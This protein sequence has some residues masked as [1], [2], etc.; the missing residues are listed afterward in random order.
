[1][2]RFLFVL[3]FCFLAGC[4]KFDRLDDGG[5]TK[6]KFFNGYQNLGSDP[7]LSATMN[8]GIMIYAYSA[9]YVTNLKLTDETD[10]SAE[11]TLPNGNYSFYAFGYT[12]ATTLLSSDVKC[13]TV[14]STSPIALDGSNKTISINLS[15][16]GCSD[17]TFN[18]NNLSY[19]EGTNSLTGDD[20]YR[21]SRIDFVFCG[22]GAATAIGTYSASTEDC[23]LN[24]SYRWGS[25]SPIQMSYRVSH[26]I[27]KIQN[28]NYQRLG[29]AILGSCVY[30]STQGL[31]V[32]NGTAL[33]RIPLGSVNKPGLFPLEVDAYTSTDCS[34]TYVHKHE[35]RKGLIFGPD[36][37]SV[38]TNYAK[39]PKLIFSPSTQNAPNYF[40]VGN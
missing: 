5:F 33:S 7:R 23:S 26:P 4:G 12:D 31:P 36:G 38:N 17:G 2:K 14:G 25:T 35:F 21:F 1:M 30:V 9:N 24:T 39:V 32:S 6:V 28:G 40:L 3:G 37:N 22:T 13:G 10:M 29:S 20:Q 18:S 15:Y 34:G 11:I 16:A 8:G 27:Y 19:T